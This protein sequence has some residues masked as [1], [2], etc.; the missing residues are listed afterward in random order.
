MS[1]SRRWSHVVTRESNA[2]D[3]EAGIIAFRDPAAI[4]R[5]LKWRY[6]FPD[7]LALFARDSDSDRSAGGIQVESHP[8][9]LGLRDVPGH[10]LARMLAPKRWKHTG[11]EPE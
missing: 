8:Q 2:L 9:R 7:A 5:S 10:E 3:L 4:A 11:R 1:C 6:G